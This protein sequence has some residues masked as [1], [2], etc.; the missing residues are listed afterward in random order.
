MRYYKDL[1][2]VEGRPYDTVYLPMHHRAQKDGTVG[3]HILVAEELL[4]RQLMDDEVVHHVDFDKKNNNPCNI[5]IFDSRRS[6]AAYH[7]AIEY[8]SNY[9]LTCVDG[10][11]TCVVVRKKKSSRRKYLEPRMQ[12]V[13]EHRCPVCGCIK[14][15][16]DR[17]CWNCYVKHIQSQSVCPEKS[18][19]VSFFAEDCN[20]VH[21]GKHFGVSDNAVRKWCK[22][23]DLPI[24]KSG[25]LSYLEDVVE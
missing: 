10:V 18:V 6:H 14:N 4:G 17:V 25:W 22:K 2:I 11:Y 7:K 16:D 21:A 24:T 9:Q 5:W 3:V 13:V 23:Y 20:F 12:V 19:L 15:R 1:A 8:G